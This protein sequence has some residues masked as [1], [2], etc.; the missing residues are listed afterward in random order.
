MLTETVQNDS[1][2]SSKLILDAIVEFIIKFDPIQI[3]YAGQTFRILL[4]KIGGGK[5]FPVSQQ[6][7]SQ[8]S[9]LLCS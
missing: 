8:G 5:M 1:Q 3:R 4:E 6:Q 7:C 9:W 2:V